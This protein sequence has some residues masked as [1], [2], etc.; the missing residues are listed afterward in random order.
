MVESRCSREVV[1]LPRVPYDLAGGQGAER[2]L[3]GDP[4]VDP[5]GKHIL[6]VKAVALAEVDTGIGEKA[7]GLVGRHKIRQ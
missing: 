1:E 4:V 3:L 5:E 7:E 2:T 6:C